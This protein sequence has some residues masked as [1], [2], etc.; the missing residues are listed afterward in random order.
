[1]INVTVECNKVKT[2]FLNKTKDKLHK[3]ASNFKARHPSMSE[4]HA[5]YDWS[6]LASEIF[7]AL[8]SP[9]V[10]QCLK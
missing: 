10:I 9:N 5:V 8:V 6:M 2:D 4:D 7:N 1:M 3:L